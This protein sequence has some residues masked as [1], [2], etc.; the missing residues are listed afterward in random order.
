MDSSYIWAHFLC[1][2]GWIY[3]GYNKF[4]HYTIASETILD[5]MKDMYNIKGKDTLT[6]K[7]N[8]Q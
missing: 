6:V 7:L 3:C 2:V 1:L 4:L 5:K 8:D